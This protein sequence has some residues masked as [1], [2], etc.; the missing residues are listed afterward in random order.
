MI[1]GWVELVSRADGWKSLAIKLI[2]SH[3]SV[4]PH[5]GEGGYI[6]TLPST[7]KFPGLVAIL[8][9]AFVLQPNN[10]KLFFKVF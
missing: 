1:E 5:W 2:T 4:G 7:N 9:L 3:F 6:F 10:K 8:Y